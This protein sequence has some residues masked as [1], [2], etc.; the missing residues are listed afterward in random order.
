MT[1]ETDAPQAVNIVSIGTD[2][3]RSEF[4]FHPERLQAILAKAPQNYNVKVVSV[5]GVF[6]SGKSFLLSWFLRHIN[7]TS[8][9]GSDDSTRWYEQVNELRKG[10]FHWRGGPERD[11][12]GIWMWN[13]PLVDHKDKSVLLL[14]DTQGMHNNETSGRLTSLLLGFTTSISSHLI[15]NVRNNIQEDYLQ[16]LT[17]FSEYAIIA[18]K[19]KK[20]NS[21]PFQTLEFLV[22]DWPY[23]QKEYVDSLDKLEEHMKDYWDKVFAGRYVEDLQ[24][25]RKLILSTFQT[26][27]CYMLCHPGDA[28]IEENFNGRVADL[29]PLFV[30]LM[31]RYCSKVFDTIPCKKIHGQAIDV[32]EFG[33]YCNMYAELFSKGKGFPSGRTQHH[34]EA[35]LKITTARESAK[36]QYRQKMDCIAGPDKRYVCPQKLQKKHDQFVSMSI[37]TFE[38]K[39]TF[40]SEEQIR[41]QKDCL[42]RE[43]EQL[44]KFYSAMN[45]P[46]ER[47]TD[48]IG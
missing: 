36:K 17:L 3:T 11:T 44:F 6:R 8:S 35:E 43:L 4:Q 14:V 2:V 16:Q 9:S 5:V 21:A 37:D 42:K 24:D 29:K 13:T 15:Y 12:I 45:R 22:R 48:Q 46:K 25:T 31:D 10:V 7:C 41:K 38:E 39:A 23:F 1:M 19:G 20:N 34:T 40:G 18:T 27:C 33:K 47:W 30:R 26:Q 28:V 32:G